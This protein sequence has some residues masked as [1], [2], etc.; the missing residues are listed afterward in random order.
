MKKKLFTIILVLFMFLP[1]FISGCGNRAGTTYITIYPEEYKIVVRVDTGTIFCEETFIKSGNIYYY[2]YQSYNDD[3]ATI[4]GINNKYIGIKDVVGNYTNY[5]LNDT[6]WYENDSISFLNNWGLNL[7][8]NAPNL[9]FEDSEKQSDDTVNGAE[10]YVYEADG[11]TYKISK[12]TDHIVWFR[13]AESTSSYIKYEVQ[14]LTM[15]DVLNG[16]S[17]EGL[18][19]GH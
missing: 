18:P 10:C 16:I 17:T 7:Y 12:S 3:F 13:Y 1:F 2:E 4:G 9:A 14:S 15:T 8:C 6:G 5:S 19:T 11:V